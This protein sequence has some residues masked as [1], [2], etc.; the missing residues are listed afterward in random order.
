M[1]HVET[2][3]KVATT[4]ILMSKKITSFQPFPIARERD[5][6]AWAADVKVVIPKTRATLPARAETIF[7]TWPYPP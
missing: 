1:E 2:V 3:N 4:A 7:F 6:P 5:A